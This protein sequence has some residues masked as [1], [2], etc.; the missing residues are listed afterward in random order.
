MAL[1]LPFLLAYP[2]SYLSRAFELS[3]VF[4]HI[5]TVNLKFLSEEVPC[6]HDRHG[7]IM[8]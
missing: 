6:I 8:T 3:R 2:W 5:W 4:T 1:G 7:V